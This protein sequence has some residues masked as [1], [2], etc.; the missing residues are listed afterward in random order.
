[1]YSSRNSI[2]DF[3]QA[4]LTLIEN[5]GSDPVIAAILAGFGYDRGRLA[6]GRRLW[7]E[8]DVLAKKQSADYAGQHGG[9]Q[10]FDKVWTSA[11]ATYIKTLKVARVAFGE[12]AT[13]ISSLK[14]YGPRK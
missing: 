13:A 3:M 12:E 10:E 11:N 8:A 14:L 2:A 7:T 1:M 5:A 4:A 6:G 9:T